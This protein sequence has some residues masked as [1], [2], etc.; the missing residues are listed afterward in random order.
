M[1][2]ETWFKFIEKHQQD[3]TLTDM[4][5]DEALLCAFAFARWDEAPARWRNDP[6]GAWF[7]RL[8]NSQREAVE[9]W[10][11]KSLSPE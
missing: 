5:N 10:R 1:T 8:S 4:S 11:L 7:T 2:R 9:D 3:K 6:W